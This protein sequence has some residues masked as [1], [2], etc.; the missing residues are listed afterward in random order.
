MLPQKNLFMI[1]LLV[2][3]V[4]VFILSKFRNVSK[5]S[6]SYLVGNDSSKSILPVIC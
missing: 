3:K 1:Q 4:P 5:R 2:R 6:K